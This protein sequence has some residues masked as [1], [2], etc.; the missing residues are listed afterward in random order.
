MLNYFENIHNL[1]SSLL[2]NCEETAKEISI[3]ER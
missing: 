1:K 2:V 3:I